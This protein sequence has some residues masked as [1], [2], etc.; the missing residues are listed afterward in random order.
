MRLHLTTAILTM[1]LAGGAASYAAPKGE[2]KD[3]VLHESG[4]AKDA[5]GAS[6]SK[7]EPT[8]TDAAM[9][10]IVVDKDKGPMKGIVIALTAPS[11]LKFYTEETDAA[12]YAEVLVPVG[13]KYELT[14]LSLGRKDIAATV[15]VTNEPNQ[16]VKL[17]LRY[18][19]MPAP[20]P[21]VMTGVTFDTGRATIRPE[22]FPQLDVV[23]AFMAHKKSARIQISGHTD[24]VGKPK[25][26][27]DLSARRALAC[28][29]YVISKGIDGSRLEAA[30]YGDE[31]PIAPND[32]D[33]G[34]QKNRRIEAKEL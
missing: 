5:R 9:R 25:A 31:H 16:N 32:T 21:F 3:F 33:E 30:G 34:R 15:S 19:G 17:T 20:P 26:N 10:F 8:K 28:R 2:S 1:T 24:N 12:G 29:A 7:I 27:K 22:S 23:V 13:Q 18:K 11:G 6:A 4:T 14:Y